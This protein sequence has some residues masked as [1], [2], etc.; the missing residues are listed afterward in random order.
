MNLSLF[1]EEDEGRDVQISWSPFGVTE[2]YAPV[3]YYLLH[4]GCGR[5]NPQKGRL[6]STCVYG[7]DQ[8]KYVRRVYR[9]I[10][11]MRLRYA[12]IASTRREGFWLT[13]NPAELYETSNWMVVVGDVFKRG[14][15]KTA[16][17]L[18]VTAA[19]LR[20]DPAA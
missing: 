15:E 13:D 10:R 6:I 1:T 19:A 12:P 20:R 16:A 3:W 9:A 5:C 11:M 14:C 4:K 2:T 8:R 7:S 18:R 17:A